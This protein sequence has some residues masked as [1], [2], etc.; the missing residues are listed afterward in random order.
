VGTESGCDVIH[1]HLGDYIV[2][3]YIIIILCVYIE[4]YFIV[5]YTSW[6]I[7]RRDNGTRRGSEREPTGRSGEKGHSGGV[8]REHT[9]DYYYYYY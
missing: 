2:G 7:G 3:K 9:R 1:I 5:V 8:V 4:I 6:N